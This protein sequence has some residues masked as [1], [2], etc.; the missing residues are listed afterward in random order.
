MEGEICHC[1]SEL[2]ELW[3]EVLKLA[4]EVDGDP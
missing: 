2:F 1:I 3:K 4:I